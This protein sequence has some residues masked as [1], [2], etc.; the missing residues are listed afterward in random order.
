MNGFGTGDEKAGG[1]QW[2]GGVDVWGRAVPLCPG[3]LIWEVQ[4]LGISS[5][6]LV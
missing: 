2:G 4:A 1:K 3:R 5:P 6:S